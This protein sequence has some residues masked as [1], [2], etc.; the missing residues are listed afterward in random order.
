[1]FISRRYCALDIFYLARTMVGMSALKDLRVILYQQ[2]HQPQPNLIMLRSRVRR[3]QSVVK[4]LL[5]FIDA[6]T[7]VRLQSNFPVINWNVRGSREQLNFPSHRSLVEFFRKDDRLLRANPIACGGF[8]TL[9]ELCG[10]APPLRLDYLL[11]AADSGMAIVLKFTES[12]VALREI[13][14]DSYRYPP[15]VLLEAVP[16]PN[17]PLVAPDVNVA[18]AINP[19]ARVRYV[20]G[21][22][23]RKTMAY[24]RQQVDALIDILNLEVVRN[25]SAFGIRLRVDLLAHEGVEDILKPLF[26]WHRFKWLLLYQPYYINSGLSAGKFDLTEQQVKILKRNVRPLMTRD[27]YLLVNEKLWQQI[28][29]DESLPGMTIPPKDTTTASPTTIVVTT[30]NNSTGTT[31]VTRTTAV[32]KGESGGSGRASQWGWVGMLL[33][34]LSLWLF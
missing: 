23:E 31:R 9:T 6:D 8:Y 3:L 25:L 18:E 11:Q 14:F 24:E 30:P 26:H 13:P 12:K 17:A 20:F 34:F 21:F 22:V 28:Y 4:Q 7:E 27:T 33:W 29:S 2:S 32:L 1:M 19:R 5:L 10:D 15:M 16:G